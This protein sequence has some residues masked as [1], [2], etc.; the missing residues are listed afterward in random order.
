[1]GRPATRHGRPRRW[2]YLNCRWEGWAGH[3]IQGGQSS[4][5]MQPPLPPRR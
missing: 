3:T 4:A 2:L 1:M 5:Y